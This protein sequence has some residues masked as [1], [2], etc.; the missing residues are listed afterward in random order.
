LLQI[1]EDSIIAVGVVEL[2]ESGGEEEEELF[3]L[4][5][6]GF[7]LLLMLVLSLV[8]CL[9]LLWVCSSYIN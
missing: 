2:P 1:E 5:D 8:D 7:V 6:D 4:A 3:E 9:L